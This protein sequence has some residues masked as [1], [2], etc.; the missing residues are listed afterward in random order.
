MYAWFTSLAT[1]FI[2]YTWPRPLK[3]SKVTQQAAPRPVQRWLQH[4][5][6]WY[7]AARQEPRGEALLTWADSCL[8]VHG[9][10]GLGGEPAGSQGH[11]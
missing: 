8:G 4:P 5:P 10:T 9:N 1:T 3:G 7:A 6:C 11:H 2:G